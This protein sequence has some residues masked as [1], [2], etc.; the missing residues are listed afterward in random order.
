MALGATA[1]AA[2]WLVLRDAVLMI[3][4]GLAIALPFVSALGKLVESQ[5]YGIKATDPLTIAE[6]ALVLAAASLGAA[7]VPA[8]QAT[9][10]NPI[11]ALRLD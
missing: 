6:A 10:V 1:R 9:R 2:I 4:A 7:L 3:G 11:D 8:W 5:L